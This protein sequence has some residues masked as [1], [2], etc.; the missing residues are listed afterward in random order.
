MSEVLAL[1]RA[2]DAMLDA[3]NTSADKH[4]RLLQARNLLCVLMDMLEDID[5]HS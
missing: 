1:L 4:H 5:A 2:I 3:D